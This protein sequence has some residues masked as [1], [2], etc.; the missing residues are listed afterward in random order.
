M[1]SPLETN[2]VIVYFNDAEL[3]GNQQTEPLLNRARFC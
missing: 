3:A 1:H 2:V